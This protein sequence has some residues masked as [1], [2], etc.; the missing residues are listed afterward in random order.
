MKKSLDF[1]CKVNDLQKTKRYG[2][3]P[4]FWESTSEH[5]FK[6]VLIVDYFYRKLHLNLDY[7]KCI[8][9]ALY[10]DFGEM[11]MDKDFDIKE[12]TDD[13]IKIRK[14]EYESMKI[15][16]LSDKYSE[17]IKRYF[18]EFAECATKEA[19]YVNVCDKLEGMIHP[20]TVGE[21]IMNH[22]LFAV[23]ADKAVLRMPELLPFYREIKSVLKRKYEEWGFEWKE[24]YETV[25][26]SE[27]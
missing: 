6:L 24:E 15:K 12:C 13:Q 8:C 11:D 16:D 10:H 5:V 3:Y 19:V 20:L 23:Y 17:D 25:F 18:D 26:Q 27:C 22:E 2:N 9:L 14:K 1:L 7:Q 21:P 4:A